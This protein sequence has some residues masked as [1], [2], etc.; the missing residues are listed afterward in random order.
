MITPSASNSDL[1]TL[2]YKVFH[3]T[4]PSDDDQADAAARYLKGR[5]TFVVGDETTFGADVADRIAKEVS[6]AGRVKVASDRKDFTAVAEQVAG[7]GADAVYFAGIGD[8]GGLFVKAL[9]AVDKKITIVGGD[10]LIASSFFDGAGDADAGVVA[11][12]PCVPTAVGVAH[13]DSEF[14]AR[15]GTGPGFYAPEAYDATQILLSGIRAGRT[16]REDLLDWVD[17]YDADGISRHLHFAANG[18]LDTPNLKV[19]AY[20]VKDGSF[21]AIGVI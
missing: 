17:G 4:L 20:A 15:Y 14:Q 6:L 12:C 16:S 1:T 19:W 7:S 2:G 9:R 10:R 5:K 13:F 8:D 3:R 18:G 11:T 21:T